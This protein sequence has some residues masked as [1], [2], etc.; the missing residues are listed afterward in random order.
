MKKVIDVGVFIPVGNH[1]WIHSVNSPAVED[2]SFRRVLEVVRGAE[3]LGFDFVLSPGIWRGR[4]GPSEHWMRSL[5]SMTTSAALLQATSRIGVFGT[6]HMT[7]YEP[8]IIAKMMTTL[9]QISPGRVGL[10]LVTGSSYLDL[11]HVGLWRDGLSHDER[12]DLADEWIKVVKRLWTEDVVS[13]KGDFYELNE[14]T[15]GPK[16]STLPPLAN[17]G[18]SGRG[19]RFAAEN[20]DIAFIGSGEGKY[21]D[22]GRQAKAVARDMGKTDLKIYGLLNVIPGATDEEAQARLDH[23][24]EGVDVE[25]LDDIALGYDMNPNAKDV[26]AASKRMAGE[27]KRT[28]VPSSTLVGSYDS[29]CRRIANIVSESELDGVILIVPDYVE[30]LK[31]VA[32]KVLSP[33]SEYGVTCRV[34]A[35]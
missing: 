21:I 16:P 25:C 15:M 11:S 9:D 7:V 2:G 28:A 29:L 33:M 34:T 31:A 6:I 12:Y 19:F 17:A 30:D 22:I 32:E 8:A 23:F 26:S 20:C 1:G 5:E 35:Q 14:A 24:N 4:K 27:G 13:H 3:A 10:N 18:A